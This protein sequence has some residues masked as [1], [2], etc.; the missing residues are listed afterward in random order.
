MKFS[1]SWLREWVNVGI[2]S[3]ELLEQ[4]TLLGLEV[5][6]YT[7]AGGDFSGVVVGEITAAEQH[8]DADRLRVCKVE[9][10]SGE[11][12]NV[13]C[14]A[15]NARVGI[16][17]PFARVGAELPGNFKIKPAKLR[18]VE[19]F[20]MLC[21]AKELELSEDANGLHELPTDAPAGATLNEYLN[22]DDHIIEIDLTPN[23]GD[24]LSIRGIAREISTRNSTAM[25]EPMVAAAKATHQ[26]EFPVEIASDSCCARFCGRVIRGIDA[27]A[28]TPLW[29][30]EKLRRS[31]VRSISASVDVTNYVMLE[32]GQPMHAFDLHKLSGGI[33]VRLATAK[34]KVKLLDGREVELDADTTVIADHNKAVAIAG[35]MG[36]DETGV[37]DNTT[38]IMLEAALFMPR[39][40]AGRPRRYNAY[41]DSA[42]RFER[43]IDSELQMFGMERATKLLVDIVGG[44]VGPVFEVRNDAHQR[45]FEQVSLKR[46]RLDRFL[47]V[48]VADE[49]VS[50][51]FDRLGIEADKTDTGW[52]ATSPTWRWDI[53]IEEDLIEE[54]ARVHGFNHIP[55]TNPAWVPTIVQ[56][57]EADMPANTLPQ[58]LVDRGYQEA[59]CYSFV[60]Q[61]Q[62]GFDPDIDALALANPISAELAEMRHTLWLGLCDVMQSNINRQQNDIKL[63]ECG[64]KFVPQADELIQKKVISGLVAGNRQEE[65][66]SDSPTAADFYDVK[67]D[68]EALLN[69]ASGKQFSI[70][71]A[72]HP[73]LHPGISAA[74]KSGDQTVGW[75][76]SMHPKL[77]KTLDLSQAPILFEIDMAEL[78][79]VRVPVYIEVSKFPSVRRDLAVTLDQDI[80][81]ATIKAC[82]EKHATNVVRDVRLL[83][84]YAGKGITVGLRSVALGLILQDFSS[85]LGDTDIETATS[86]ILE[87]LSKDLGATLRT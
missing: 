51:I 76:G 6:D 16:K 49:K 19:S 87:G 30:V 3:E 61:R 79:V 17:V 59:V 9:D 32:M 53:A 50:D 68:V 86:Q 48:A 13:V 7:S 67:S 5:D 4:L 20:G 23:R 18:G 65:H 46:E 77:Q 11:L 57:S 15:P 75:L 14:G 85:T 52:Q 24:C 38:D 54:V 37:S 41:T 74:I 2:G 29:M 58:L 44:E 60:D 28:S 81:F 56:S 72:Q 25:I 22:L 39:G 70:Q 31:G 64:L 35:I 78:E 40:I 36:G 21:S 71:P 27:T 62:K 84:V 63:F 26:D 1:E 12:H 55:R 82:V 42:Q 43:G 33:K 80:P 45:S 34:E 66:W 8:P 47:G 73:A 83:D 69:A 10:G